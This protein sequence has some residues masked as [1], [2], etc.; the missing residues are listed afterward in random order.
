MGP[1][2]FPPQRGPRRRTTGGEQ[3][4][5]SFGVSSL[6]GPL[7]RDHPAGDVQLDRLVGESAPKLVSLPGIGTDHA[8]T[9]LT[10]VGDNPERG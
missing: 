4:R 3:V 8:A 10:V 5:A 9:L 1:P 7:R 2:A 6:G